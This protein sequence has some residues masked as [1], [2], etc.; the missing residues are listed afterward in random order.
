MF[1]GDRAYVTDVQASPCWLHP[2]RE[3]ISVDGLRG[4]GLPS[5]N[6]IIDEFGP[7][8]VVDKVGNCDGLFTLTVSSF[9]DRYSEAVAGLPCVFYI[10]VLEDGANDG[11]AADAPSGGFTVPPKKFPAVGSRLTTA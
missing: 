2:S 9:I 1:D 11:F 7:A 4:V 5:V 6:R 10:W 8:V 3:E